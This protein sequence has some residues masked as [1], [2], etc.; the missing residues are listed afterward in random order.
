MVADFRC[1]R[2]DSVYSLFNGH[3][4]WCLRM[5]AEKSYPRTHRAIEI[6]ATALYLALLILAIH[7]AEWAPFVDGPLGWLW[8][9]SA[10]MVGLACADFVSGFVHWLADTFGSVNMP[11]IGPA[12]I[13]PFR[14]HHHD[15]LEITRHDFIEVNGNN[16]V[17]I[18]LFLPFVANAQTFLSAQAAA[19]LALWT[20]AFTLAIFLTNQVHAWAHADKV[21]RPIEWLQRARIILNARDHDRH[22]AA[23]HDTYYCITFGWLNPILHKIRFFPILTVAARPFMPPADGHIP[24][25]PGGE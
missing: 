24:N 17:V 23:P 13:A 1:V 25:A 20:V 2:I 14:E 3:K 8:A 9:F 18:L 5:Q 6:S 10:V 7:N 15:P 19:W 11:L 22:H 16:C 12:Y 4:R 21:P